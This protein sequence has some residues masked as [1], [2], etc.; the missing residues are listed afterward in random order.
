MIENKVIEPLSNAHFQMHI[1]A[2]SEDQKAAT[3]VLN[4]AVKAIN[5]LT[6]KVDK[7]MQYIQAQKPVTPAENLKPDIDIIRKEMKEIRHMIYSQPKKI[8]NWPKVNFYPE[9]NP[10][11]FYKAL[12]ILL[13]VIFGLF[14][15]VLPI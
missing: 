8:F 3:Q 13:T 7:T 5:M 2:F 11:L 6:D 15:P 4:D 1:E 10:K 9:H 14:L 12:V